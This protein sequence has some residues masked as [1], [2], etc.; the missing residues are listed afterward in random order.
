MSSNPHHLL[1]NRFTA[2][3]TDAP[4]IS[5]SAIKDVFTVLGLSGQKVRIDRM[6]HEAQ[7][8]AAPLHLMRLFG[9]SEVTAVRY[10][11]VA[12]P[13]RIVKTLR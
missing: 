10:V 3:N 12:H 13:E 9:I 5:C 8:T 4:P 6:L 2:M 1:V 11:H 7:L